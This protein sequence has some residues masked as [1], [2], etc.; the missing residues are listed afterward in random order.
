MVRAKILVILM[1]VSCLA[2]AAT[3]GAQVVIED[4]GADDGGALAGDPEDTNPNDPGDPNAPAGADPNQVGAGDDVGAGGNVGAGDST[5]AGSG[6]SSSS[7]T[8]SSTNA[9]GAGG[10]DST[11]TTTEEGVITIDSQPLAET[12]DATPYLAFGAVILLGLGIV[13]ARATSGFATQQRR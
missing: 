8:S 12:G 6:S 3:A 1:A 11:T 2:F 9:A 5:G 7:S 10:A 4:G 13:L